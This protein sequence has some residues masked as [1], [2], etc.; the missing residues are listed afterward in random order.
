MLDSIGRAPRRSSRPCRA[1]RMTGPAQ[2]PFDA[3]EK[4][5]EMAEAVP[6]L[7]P[8]DA[9]DDANQPV[10]SDE[11]FPRPSLS[12]LTKLS[13]D[14]GIG[15]ARV[16]LLAAVGSQ[17]EC[18]AVAESLIGDALRRGLS[19]ARVD[20][21]S[22]LPSDEPGLTDLA[23]DL[24]SFGDVVQKSVREGLSEVPWGQ[25]ATINRRSMKPV[26]LVEALADIC[27]AVIVSTGRVGVTSSLPVFAGLDCR[28]V[29]VTNQDVTSE[30]IAAAQGD[31]EVLGY[32]LIQ[33]VPVPAR[34]AA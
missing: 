33:V 23:A 19:L 18:A 22:G 24:V 7:N 34:R 16:V 6:L 20:A 32:Q 31:A 12:E 10:V 14:I 5:Q 8:F 28:L 30:E 4:A 9:L 26:T 27:E 15:R 25:V 21:G 13:A 2:N 29:L 3:P 17:S 1:G 11:P